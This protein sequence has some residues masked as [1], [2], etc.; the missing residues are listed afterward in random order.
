M[1]FNVSNPI[2][3]GTDQEIVDLYR[4]CLVA[5]SFEGQSHT[6]G[7]RTFTHADVNAVQKIIET[8]EARV[9]AAAGGGGL[10]GACNYAA[11]RRPL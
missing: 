11:R 4:A 2:G 1:A 10:S 8:Y 7:N 5:I 3:T 9:R 6:I